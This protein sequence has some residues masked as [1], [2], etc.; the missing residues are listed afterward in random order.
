M[1]PQ[2]SMRFSFYTKD[3]TARQALR[4]AILG[5]QM[6]DTHIAAL[7]YKVEALQDKVSELQAELEQHGDR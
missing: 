2:E 1:P 6:L 5:L 4:Q 7:E 3:W